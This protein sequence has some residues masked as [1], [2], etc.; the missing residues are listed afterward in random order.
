MPLL[1]PQHAESTEDRAE[2]RLLRG[3]GP[4]DTEVYGT[5]GD[6]LGSFEE[7][8]SLDRQSGAVMQV[9]P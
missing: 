6:G 4:C 2:A 9:G 8:Y 3:Y 5:A 1:R 7:L